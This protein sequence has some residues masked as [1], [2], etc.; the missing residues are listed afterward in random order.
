MDDMLVATKHASI[1][2]DIGRCPNRSFETNDVGNASHYLGIQME[3]EENGTFLLHQRN[4]IED[5]LSAY[6]MK[7]AKPVVMPME[8]SYLSTLYR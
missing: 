5:I 3:R 7:D 6:N 8:M 4:K 2:D 1:I